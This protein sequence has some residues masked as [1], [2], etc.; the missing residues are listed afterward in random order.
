[1]AKEDMNGDVLVID[2]DYESRWLAEYLR[3]Q[4]ETGLSYW[5]L[6]KRLGDWPT[7]QPD[8]MPDLGGTATERCGWVPGG[9]WDWNGAAAGSWEVRW[10]NRE[11][12][13]ASHGWGVVSVKGAEY[14][15]PWDLVM[16]SSAHSTSRPAICEKRESACVDAPTVMIRTATAFPA[17][18]ADQVFEV[19]LT[20]S[21]PINNLSFDVDFTNP[22]SWQTIG[23]VGGAV[24]SMQQTGTH[25]IK[26]T[27]RAVQPGWVT[28]QVKDMVFT[29]TADGQQ[30]TA[31]NKLIFY[32]GCHMAWS[33]DKS[34]D[35][36]ETLSAYRLCKDRP[37]CQIY[38]FEAVSGL[39]GGGTLPSACHIYEDPDFSGPVDPSK[40]KSTRS[41]AERTDVTAPRLSLVRKVDGSGAILGGGTLN[42]FYDHSKNIHMH[43]DIFLSEPIKYF[44]PS[45]LEVTGQNCSISGELGFGGGSAVLKKKSNG[46]GTTWPPW[47]TH[48]RLL[49]RMDESPPW[50]VTGKVTIALSP[51]SNA[52]DFS[53]SP[54]APGS[55]SIEFNIIPGCD[56][57]QRMNDTVLTGGTLK[58]WMGV[59]GHD[60]G[61]CAYTCRVEPSCSGFSFNKSDGTCCLKWGPQEDGEGGWV[62]S[63]MT[64]IDSAV[65]DCQCATDCF[66]VFLPQVCGD[67]IVSG[68]ET[69]DDGNEASLDGCSATCQEEDGWLCMTPGQLCSPL[70]CG[71]GLLAGSEQC[72]DNNTASLDGCSDACQIEEGWT[73]PTPGELCAP[74]CGDGLLKGN[75]QCDDGG[76]N[77]G[78]GCSGSCGIES[79]W[80]CPTPGSPCVPKCGDDIVV[81]NETCDDG[82]EA[83]LDG[84]S[85][86]CTVEP[87]WTCPIPG[88]LCVRIPTEPPTTDSCFCSEGFGCVNNV[89][90]NCR[91]A[92]D[93]P[94]RYACYQDWT[95]DECTEAGANYTW[96]GTAPTPPPSLIDDITDDVDKLKDEQ[97][98]NETQ[99]GDAIDELLDEEESGGPTAPP[100]DSVDAFAERLVRAVQVANA[101]K[102]KDMD[103]V[104]LERNIT[105]GDVKA[106]K[107][108]IMRALLKDIAKVATERSTGGL[109]GV[110]STPSEVLLSA[111]TL[112]TTVEAADEAESADIDDTSTAVSAFTSLANISK[113]AIAQADDATAAGTAKALSGVEHYL[114]AAAGL[115]RQLKRTAK[116]PPAPQASRRLTADAYH[117]MS[118]DIHTSTAWLGDGLAGSLAA[119]ARDSV[120]VVSPSGG[121]H[122][123]VADPARVSGQPV[124]TMTTAQQ[125]VAV[126]FPSSVDSSTASCSGAQSAQS[127][128]MTFWSQDPYTY[129]DSD[130]PINETQTNNTIKSAAQ[131]TLTVESRQCGSALALRSSSVDEPF[132]LFLPRPSATHLR[133]LQS[134]SV[135][136]TVTVEE[137]CGF[138]NDATHQW[139]TQGCRTS[140]ARSNATTLCCECGHLTSFSSLFRSVIRESSI[141]DVLGGAGDSLKNMADID[142]WVKNIAGTFVLVMIAIHLVCLALSIYFDCRHPITDQILLDI[143]MTDPLLDARHAAVKSESPPCTYKS[144]ALSEH[145]KLRSRVHEPVKP[146]NDLIKESWRSA[147]P[148][149]TVDSRLIAN[150]AMSGLSDVSLSEFVISGELSPRKRIIKH[151]GS[152]GGSDS[153]DRTPVDEPRVRELSFTPSDQAVVDARGMRSMVGPDK[154]W[155]DRPKDVKLIKSGVLKEALRQRLLLELQRQQAAAVIIQRR[156]RAILERMVAEADEQKAQEALC[157]GQAEVNEAPVRPALI[158]RPQLQQDTADATRHARHIQFANMG[159]QVGDADSPMSIHRLQTGMSV[160]PGL[161]KIM[162]TVRD[163]IEGDTDSAGG[164]SPKLHTGQTIPI[165]AY[166]GEEPDEQA[167]VKLTVDRETKGCKTG[168]KKSVSIVAEGDGKGGKKRTVAAARRKSVTDSWLDVNAEVDLMVTRTLRRVEYVEWGP[169]KMFREVVRRDHPLF[170]LFILNPTYTAVQRTLFFGSISLGI[171]TMCAVFFDR[172]RQGAGD[173]VLL[174]FNGNEIAWQLTLRQLVVLLWSIILAKPIPL[175]LILL[176]RKAVPHIRP[177]ARR[178]TAYSLKTGLSQKTAFLRTVGRPV[179]DITG[180]HSGHFPLST[181]MAVLFRWRLKERIGI[182]I[183]LLY[184]F[185]CDAFLLLFA[186]SERLAESTPERPPRIIYQDFVLA[187]TVE[188]LNSFIIQPIL[189]FMVLSLLLMAILR[190]GV[191]DW[192]VWFMPHWFDFSFSGAQGIHELTIQLQAITDTHELARGILGFAGLNI[193]SIGM[194][195]DVFT[196]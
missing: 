186:F 96:C 155:K 51:S 99:V 13:D 119:S 157:E 37:A 30:N 54:I 77:N 130:V 97:A 62:P 182:A 189:F 111:V 14:D 57:M 85:S 7:E 176:F 40:V 171:L 91:L 83:S 18:P 90:S 50:F 71:D 21:D 151:V 33:E 138:W 187:C 143:W 35:P 101:L 141:E 161:E 147:K 70:V 100:I 195:Q 183:G 107:R 117:N 131:G 20:F 15:E 184:W 103:G 16:V 56:T 45:D 127:I 2:D 58:D 148:K 146:L 165:D 179:A 78:D 158:G 19:N 163:D 121:T 48:F 60:F 104:L 86:I 36:S 106:Q 67:G 6:F 69:C 24:A 173:T 109:V 72:D 25:E 76:I 193:D 64:S 32:S 41:C 118:S 26:E 79:G 4:G 10:D 44:D 55:A 34:V 22:A 27:I 23:G 120:E 180:R 84:C 177:S 93:T 194:V 190:I 8:K 156:W 75:E 9:D 152:E 95:A 108:V 82:N 150:K 185:A 89:C 42:A 135:N 178:S 170:K 105:D 181:K 46:I 144:C 5:T 3:S 159:E 1:M 129:A 154:D 98:L 47:D 139:D 113:D 168:Y 114:D 102:N 80:L 166:F 145:T 140:E 167:D 169:S 31:S 68:N 94:V 59:P 74:I 116:S 115:F 149:E 142:A 39:P 164:V 125:P 191:C 52:K 11:P 112:A 153:E 134:A 43:V 87:G 128:Q 92:F 126:S 196:F 188:L 53:N 172:P 137:A 12:W 49:L 123:K 175:A 73:C 192:V 162:S 132:R 17:T 65:R 28:L 160:Q 63:A 133:R 136:R 174:A 88:S 61:S 81:G 122:I 66:E 110:A 29:R 38:V 124:L